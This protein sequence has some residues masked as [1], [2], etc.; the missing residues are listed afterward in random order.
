[1]TKQ[2]KLRQI[3][4]SVGLVLPKELLAELHLDKDDEVTVTR[5]ENGLEISPYD[6]D[7]AD[8]QKWIEKGARRY[9]NALRALSK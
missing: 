6:A 4:N 2:V 3:G 1:M 5:S 7:M 9:R 8:A